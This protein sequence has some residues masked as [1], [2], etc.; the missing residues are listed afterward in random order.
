[1]ERIEE[2][3]EWVNKWESLRSIGTNWE[4]LGLET[5]NIGNIEHQ[6]RHRMN[7]LLKTPSHNDHFSGGSP[8]LGPHNNGFAAPEKITSSTPSPSPQNSLQL[9]KVEYVNMCFCHQVPPV[10][11]HMESVCPF[12]FLKVT[13]EDV[14]ECHTRGVDRVSQPFL[15]CTCQAL[16]MSMADHTPSS[17]PPWYTR[18]SASHMIEWAKLCCK[19]RCEAIKCPIWSKSKHICVLAVLL[20]PSPIPDCMEGFPILRP[21]LDTSTSQNKG[22]W[23]PNKSCWSFKIVTS[24][25][26]LRQSLFLDG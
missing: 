6:F 20:Q 8:V 14:L 5:T 2:L 22:W 9:T 26:A 11:H 17:P 18:W 23:N 25:F 16:D 3:E 10:A 24:P 19:F 12:Y 1:M 4:N 7:I 21:N 13:L 15:S